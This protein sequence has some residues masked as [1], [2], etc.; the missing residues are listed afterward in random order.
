MGLLKILKK[1]SK[2][3]NQHTPKKT[4]LTGI[5]PTGQI[6]VGNYFG[7]FK[8]AIE[9]T[10][11]PEYNCYLFLANLHALNSTPNPKDLSKLTHQLAVDLLSLGLDPKQSTLFVQ[12]DISAHTEFTWILQNL[13][14]LGSLERAHAYKDAIENKNI[15]HNEIN[16]GLYAYPILMASDILLYKPDLVPV[17]QDQKQHIEIARNL[18]QKYNTTYKGSL[19]LPEALIQKDLNI[20][21]GTDGRKMSKSYNNYI[22]IFNDPQKPNQIKKLI[23][24]IQTDSKSVEEVKDP[25]TCNVFKIYE[26]FASENQIENL[27][28]KYLEGGFGYGDAKKE[29]LQVFTEYFAEANNKRQKL[30]QNPDFVKDVLKEGARKA[31]LK[32]ERTLNQ[33]Y[34]QAGLK[35]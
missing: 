21:Q 35:L 10:Q 24:S 28:D 20:V 22:P 3:N 29:L 19:K 23:M 16:L 8:P 4:I 11:N 31:K 1:K 26:L 7:A 17:G 14:N 30:L 2:T 18:A 5:K 15:P 9:L 25:L 6:H 34:K 27:R 33:V 12:S 32:A 13:I